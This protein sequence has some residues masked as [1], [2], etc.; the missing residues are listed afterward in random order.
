MANL[1]QTGAELPG[2]ISRVL[3]SPVL[4]FL[5]LLLMGSSLCLESA[6]AADSKKTSAGATAQRFK[7]AEKLAA[8][9]RN[10]DCLKALN[11]LISSSPG[12]APAYVLR[13]WQLLI[14]NKP[15]QSM[16]D[17]N[18]A[19]KLD[20]GNAGAFKARGFLNRQ[21]KQFEQSRLDLEKAARLSPGDAEINYLHGITCLLQ[22]LHNQAI[23]DFSE[24]IKKAPDHPYVASAYYWRGR[25]RQM[26]EKDKEAVADFTRCME[27][28]PGSGM[29]NS[30][31]N[32]PPSNLDMLYGTSTKRSKLGLLE[33]GIS[34]NK[35]GRFKE[36]EK[37][38]DAVLAASPDDVLIIEERGNARLR[39]GKYREATLDFNK[40]ILKGTPSTELYYKMGL[41]NFCAGKYRRSAI[42]FDAWF[43]RNGFNEKGSALALLLTWTSHNRLKDSKAMA[44]LLKKASAARSNPATTGVLNLLKSGKSR[45]ASK[46]DQSLARLQIALNEVGKKGKEAQARSQLNWIVK[47]AGVLSDEYSVA[48][49]ELKRLETPPAKAR[50]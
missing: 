12:F 24:S 4:L 38:F 34:Y 18:R 25:A 49:A 30:R 28:D 23:K 10:Q 31:S 5:A 7:E 36:A 6:R 47:N 42:S 3:I 20:P 1:R 17:Y 22:G 21:L 45:A 32:K 8:A 26:M 11:S 41:T 2:E 43:E 37:D 19:I 50:G 9:S 33:R 48:E 16:Q 44:D 15:D 29:S 13:G 14:L 27:K 46:N 40:A 39:Q 35:L